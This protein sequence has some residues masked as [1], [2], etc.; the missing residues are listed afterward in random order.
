MPSRLPIDAGFNELKVQ[1]RWRERAKALEHI[2]PFLTRVWQAGPL[3]A[4][5]GIAS[6]FCRA[7]IP[8][9]SLYLSKRIIDIIVHGVRSGNF[10]LPRLWT[11]VI[12]AFIIAIASDLL[13]RSTALVESLL[14]DRFINR[15]SVELM[16]HAV[17]LD[18]ADL[19]NPEFYDKLERARRNS[20]TRIQLTTLLFSSGQDFVT[21][22]TLTGALALYHPWL[23]LLLGISAVPAFI[24]ETR[25]GA[26]SYS[27]LNRLT[28]QRR[29]LDYLR[30]LGA[31][32]ETAKEVKIFGLG[33][34]FCD[35]Y[36]NL[37]ENYYQQNSRLATRR[38]ISGYCLGSISTVA[39]YAAYTIILYQATHGAISVG[40]LTLL[41][42]SFA[43]SRSLIE[44]I[45]LSIANIGEHALNL[46]DLF[47][48]FRM[49]PRIRSG[50]IPAP[51]SMRYGLEFRHVS[52]QYPDSQKLALVD[53]SFRLEVGQRIAL[54]GENGAGKSTIAK[55]ICRLYDPSEGE[56]LV[57]GV[58]LKEYDLSGW[59][60]LIGILFQDFVHYNLLF[61]ENIGLGRVEYLDDVQR[62]Q[63][64]AKCSGALDIAARLHH[65]MNQMLGR[66]FENGVNLSGGEWQ[67][68]A[69]A[70]AYLRDADLLILDE[71]TA[72][73]DAAAEYDIFQRLLA[74]SREKTA[75]LISHRFSMARMA[76]AIL[77]VKDG[78][79]F[80][81]GSH[82]E[83]LK[84]KGRYSELFE[85]QAAGYR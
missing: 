14:A 44:S 26:L 15:V 78:R 60:R 75:V 20:S 76:D 40:D 37:A 80:E 4:T 51:R 16:A 48:F 63:G 3:L 45:L 82:E 55:L 62:I 19:E 8:V 38:A 25:F 69:L 66:M 68:V 50:A 47:T 42:G 67:K 59:R 29:E 61:K 70:R 52:F 79:V 5:A 32:Q 18:L 57:D 7:A 1:H 83:L 28:P 35:R 33:E 27:L 36:R 56:I 9:S 53:I 71:P 11:L 77:V 41:S 12:A 24:G 31:S 81:S 72:A 30:I 22:F 21:L 6:R 43:Q 49:Q 34:Y 54:I 64:A 84:R 58:N 74:L 2:G 17:R 39:Y 10:D 65:G 73:L 23:L 85:L 46:D 13:A